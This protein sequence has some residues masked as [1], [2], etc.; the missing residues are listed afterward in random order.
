M[1]GVWL[2]SNLGRNSPNF[3]RKIRKIFLTLYAFVKQ[4][5]IELYK[6]LTFFTSPNINLQ[7]FAK[8]Q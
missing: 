3:A 2:V 1:K 8:N 4:L 5:F 7:V 6:Q